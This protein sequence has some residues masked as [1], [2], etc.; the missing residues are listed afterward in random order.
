[1]QNYLTLCFFEHPA[2]RIHLNIWEELMN[3]Q[4]RIINK[5]KYKHC[6]GYIVKRDN[7]QEIIFC[8]PIGLDD[9]DFKIKKDL[10][11]IKEATYLKTLIFGKVTNKD[12]TIIALLTNYAQSLYA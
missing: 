5:F 10:Q 1:M 3:K 11:N 2:A 4:N 12:L 6:E 7:D 8:A 9:P